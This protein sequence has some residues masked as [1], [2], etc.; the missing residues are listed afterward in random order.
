LA[1]VRQGFAR[2]GFSPPA[3]VAEQAEP[4]GAF[5][6]LPK[7]NPEEPGALDLLLA[8]ATRTGAD[9]ALANDPDADRLAVG[10]PHPRPPSGRGV[11]TGDEIV[12]LLADY[13]IRH[14]PAVE[15]RVLVTTI[16]SAGLLGE[17]AAA[18]G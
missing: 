17:L 2:A 6:T 7:P 3:V 18:A 9:L 5:P 10:L 8:E 14:P 4:D 15:Q 12:A 11:L 1:T 16:V 13:L